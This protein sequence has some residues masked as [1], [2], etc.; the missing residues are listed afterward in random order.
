MVPTD[1]LEEEHEDLGLALALVEH[2]QALV[3]NV[4]SCSALA[5]PNRRHHRVS[6]RAAAVECEDAAGTIAIDRGN[7]LLASERHGP[8]RWLVSG[9][10]AISAVISSCLDVSPPCST[11]CLS[12]SRLM[13]RDS[14][15]EKGRAGCAWARARVRTVSFVLT[16]LNALSNKVSQRSWQGERV[17]RVTS[18]MTP[19]AVQRRGAVD[20]AA[21]VAPIT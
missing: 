17:A 19:A 15:P 18:R 12:A 9:I 11:H 6:T 14:S 2:A 7:A 5:A 13:S 4:C 20:E 3:C 1:L 8:M 16:M 21:T 10:P